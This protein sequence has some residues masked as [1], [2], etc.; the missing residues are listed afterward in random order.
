M[1]PSDEPSPAGLDN[2]F[3]QRRHAEHLLRPAQVVSY[4]RE[5]APHAIGY[6]L[7]RRRRASELPVGVSNWPNCKAFTAA[8]L[9]VTFTMTN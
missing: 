6:A 2:R 1:K 4:S 7:R 3:R 8:N 9:T 5:L